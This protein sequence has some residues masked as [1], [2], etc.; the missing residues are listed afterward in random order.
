M[1]KF[2]SLLAVSLTT[3]MPIAAQTTIQ[4]LEKQAVEIISKMTLEE[5]ISQMMN[6]TPGIERLGIEPYDYW[7]EGLH[8]VGRNGRATVFPEPIGLGATFDTELINQ[9]GDV[10][11][12]ESRAK[13]MVARKNKNYARYTGLTFWSPNINIFRDPRWGRGMET[14]GEDPFLTGSLGTAFVKGMQGND[15]V[16][17]KVAACGK[18]FAVHSGP[19][20]TRHSANIN[21]SKRDLWETYLPAFRM[22]VQDAN[23]EIIMG[24]YNRVYGE[25][26]SGSKYLLTDVLRNQWGFKGHIV[27]DCDAVDDIYKG[28]G[29]VKTA[30]EASALAIKNGL[31]IECGHSLFA[32]KE[33]VEKNLITEAELDKALMPLMMTR[34]KLG[35]LQKDDNCPYNN[36][37]ESDICSPKHTAL[38]KKAALES[39][40]LLKNNGILPLKKDIHT[41]FVTG[42][43]AA[44]A[45][46]LMGNYF[47]ISDRYCTYLQGIVSKVS[48]G[49]AVNYRPGVLENT[50][51]KNELNYAVGEAARTQYTIIVM[52]NN[53]NLEGE[54]GESIDSDTK[55]DRT[56]L[57]LPKS[58]MDY[59]REIYQ[60]KQAFAKMR[61]GANNSESGI[62]VVLT[63]GS[64]IDVREI[65][66]MADAVIMAWYS[67][68][69]GGYALGDLIFGDANFSGRLPITFPADGAKLPDF[70]D[71]SMKNRT[72]KYMSDNIFYPFGYGLSYGKIS[73]S[74]PSAV[75]NK[76]NSTTVKVKVSN[77]SNVT[78]VETVQVYVS[79]PGAGQTAPIQ[80]LAAFKRVE[81]KPNS[82]VDVS[83]TIPVERLKTVEEDGSLKL[84]KGT[85]KFTIGG[86]APSNRTTQLG[87]GIV[88]KEVKF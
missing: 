46:W 64:P 60:R 49:T 83:F 66:E 4:R 3:V 20:S 77:S 19:E 61:G 62:I 52:G 12:T 30:A 27:S 40:V 85:Y 15:P 10:I 36:Y 87:V 45:F 79:A 1:K 35:I 13:Y 41:L 63:G 31:N 26:C 34:L 72:Y 8:G 32:L 14:Y 65:S 86:A 38:S 5:K 73:Y 76:D 88:E 80:Q 2:L 84:R 70:E 9:I 55:G 33:A 67:G 56:S 57:A 18:H 44:D 78:T 54:E 24:A 58:Q 47:G 68:Q 16:Y 81:V 17:L 25:S 51:T 11:S 43:G 82:S 59:L 28:H 71:Y 21:P 75:K 22:L 53:G 48:S 42:A 74:E 6:T 39:M 7:N 37:S 69:E 50:P 29:I 23:V